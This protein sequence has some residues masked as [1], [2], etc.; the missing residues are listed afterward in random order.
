MHANTASRPLIGKVDLIRRLRAILPAASLL[1][2]L[3]DL[4][5]SRVGP[6]ARDEGNSVSGVET[7]A[8]VFADPFAHFLP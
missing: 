2:E 3:E 7:A 5:L 4:P 6:D 8:R 1:H